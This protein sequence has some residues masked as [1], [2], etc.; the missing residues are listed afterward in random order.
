M[1]R[2]TISWL[3]HL[4]NVLMEFLCKGGKRDMGITSRCRS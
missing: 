2:S 4:P 1:Q 3:L